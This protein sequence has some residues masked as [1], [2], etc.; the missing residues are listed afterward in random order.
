MADCHIGA[1]A[2]GN[3]VFLDEHSSSSCS[4]NRGVTTATVGHLWQTVSAHEKIY[5]MFTDI[6]H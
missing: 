5:F 6:G 2:G 3:F 4:P 1:I